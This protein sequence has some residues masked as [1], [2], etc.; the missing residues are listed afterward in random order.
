MEVEEKESNQIHI[1]YKR[2]K[3]KTKKGSGDK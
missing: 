2:R 3:N 1:T